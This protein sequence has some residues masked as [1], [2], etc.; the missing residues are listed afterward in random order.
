MISP[1]ARLVANGS[2]TIFEYLDCDKSVSRAVSRGGLLDA[3]QIWRGTWRAESESKEPRANGC[4]VAKYSKNGVARAE[5]KEPRANGCAVAAAAVK[6]RRRV[7]ANHRKNSDL[8]R[9]VWGPAFLREVLRW[10]PPL[11]GFE[12]RGRSTEEI[13]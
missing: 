8:G 7:E 1:F 2:G 6:V 10:R 12:M 4:A 3:T 13:R 9:D 5:S 11:G